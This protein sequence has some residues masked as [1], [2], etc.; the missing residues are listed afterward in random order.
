MRDHPL[1]PNSSTQSSVALLLMIDGVVINVIDDRWG[2][3][4]MHIY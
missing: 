1:S 2:V 3:K 4:I